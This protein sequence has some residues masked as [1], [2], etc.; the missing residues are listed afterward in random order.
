MGKIVP[1]KFG[2]RKTDVD[3]ENRKYNELPGILAA[4][5]DT[6]IPENIEIYADDKPVSDH[7]MSIPQGIGAIELAV[8]AGQKQR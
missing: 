2:P 1:V 5:H 7:G 8:V 4:I 6:D 3:I